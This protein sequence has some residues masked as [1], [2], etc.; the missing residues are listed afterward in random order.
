[1]KSADTFSRKRITLLG[2]TGSIG[3]STLDVIARHPHRFTLVAAAARSQWKKLADIALRFRPEAVALHDANAARC[4]ADFLKNEGVSTEVF[5]GEK[6]VNRMAEWPSADTVVAA[7]TGGVGLSPTAA[8][9]RAGKRIVLANKE[10]LVMGG[11]WFMRLAREHGA[12]LLPIDSEHN[13]IFQCLP[14]TKTEGV[15]GERAAGVK[16]ILLTA[17]GGPFLHWDHARL[18]TATPEQ[19]VNHPVWK[20]GRKISVDSA[21][22]MNKGLE[23]IEAHWLFG[24]PRD[25]I[26][27]VIH[28]Q[29]IVHSMVE[30]EDGSTLAQLGTP[31]MRTPIA[32]ALA[33]PH[34]VDAGVSALTVEKMAT[35]TFLPPDFD[36][37]LCLKLAFHALTLANGAAVVLNAANEC[38]VDAFLSRKIAFL[39]IAEV[40][41]ATLNAVAS[42]A[43]NTLE[44]TLALDALARSKAIRTIEH[45]TAKK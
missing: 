5:S 17:S 3:D 37:F 31:D 26:E 4:L 19:A 12:T 14:R 11:A 42:P 2:A 25:A 41:N 22:M 44:E 7:I 1:M 13:A 16:K 24:M 6:G 30:Y 20:M 40:I 10:A 39:D 27:V 36:R 43:P 21:T 9:A 15:I 35:L 38:A 33:F 28:P 18:K 45:L 29:S 23:V 32:Q 34:R 8:A